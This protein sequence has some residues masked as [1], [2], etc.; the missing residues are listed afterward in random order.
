[1]GCHITRSRLGAVNIVSPPR[2]MPEMLMHYVQEGLSP[3]ELTERELTENST[4]IEKIFAALKDHASVDFAYYKS[5][6]IGR[7]IQRRM[8]LEQIED[9]DEYYQRLTTDPEELND[10]YHDLL[11]G[12]TQFFR[13][14][15][16]YNLMRDDVIPELFSKAK[17]DQKVLRVWVAA[18]ATGEEAYSIAI[19]LQEHI[20]K[21]DLQLDFKLFATDIHKGALEKASL[22]AYS[23]ESVAGMDPEYLER[24]LRKQKSLYHIVPGLR[25]KVVF[26][27]HN[28]LRDAPF[29]QLDL[30]TCRNMMIYL[31]PGAQRKTL[32][33]FHFGLKAGGVLF[34][35][36]S[37][38]PGEI[39]DEFRI[40]DKRWRIYRKRRNIRL[41]M[42]PRIPS[43]TLKDPTPEQIPS[44][45]RRLNSTEFRFDA[46]L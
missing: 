10:L 40:I 24:Y 11:I 7:R 8:T 22:G 26:A 4:G 1:M 37:E 19:L 38:T 12:V 13:D 32:A 16:A 36:P 14:E 20:R 29:T 34:L 35:G 15:A 27:N 9:V 33:L 31:L 2:E 6:M 46:D 18:C 23:E 17:V 30:I 25:Q 44:S 3:D 39:M 41:S 21:H 28:V 45:A 42:E 43:N 5:G